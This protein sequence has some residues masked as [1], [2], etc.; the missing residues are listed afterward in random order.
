MLEMMPP[1]QRSWQIGK[2]LT[3]HS[4]TASS[5]MMRCA[6]AR[7]LSDS[8]AA[9]PLLARGEGAERPSHTFMLA[10]MRVSPAAIKPRRPDTRSRGASSL[11]AGGLDQSAIGGNLVGHELVHFGRRQR[12]RIDRKLL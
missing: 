12:H 5:S 8:R 11:D 2:T 6:R 1:T 7:N 10:P 3:S 4:I 9:L